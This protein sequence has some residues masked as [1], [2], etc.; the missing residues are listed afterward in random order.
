MDLMGKAA[1]VTGAGTGVGRA[2]SL[3]LARRGC[4]VLLN[5]SR[6]QEAAEKAAAEVSALGVKGVPHRCDVADDAACRAMVE[7]AVREF[8]R[9]DLLVNN[10]G[11]TS[12]IPHAELERVSDDDWDR[13]LAV[14]LK[15]P[16]QMVRAARP[17]IEA[18]GGGEVVNVSSIA[19][20][21]GIG[22]SIPYAASKAALN[23][24]T[25][26]LARVL[27]PKIRVNAV[28]PGFI[29]GAWL[30]AGL[31]PVYDVIKQGMEQRAAL[32]KV[33]EA[34][35]VADAILSLVAGSDLVTGHVLPVDG[36]MLIAG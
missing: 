8:G 13:I 10:A 31:G 33:C 24:L 6:S 34:E 23:N 22:S 5:Y 25:L 2:T 18:S 7:T 35:D 19:G 16:F 1:I 32:G 14:N 3:A 27:A 11:T 36:G 12:F 21:I 20:I 28:A 30:K 29:A 26:T 4:A 15:G 9:L 17:A